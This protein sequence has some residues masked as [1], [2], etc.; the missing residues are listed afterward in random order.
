MATVLPKLTKE[1]PRP[2]K[3]VGMERDDGT[4][5]SYLA[6]EDLHVL[7]VERDRPAN[8]QS[9]TLE[10]V[11]EKIIFFLIFTYTAYILEATFCYSVTCRV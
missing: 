2:F 7:D 10:E 9:Y 3:M 11:A 4:F 6:N 5:I 8:L 1:L